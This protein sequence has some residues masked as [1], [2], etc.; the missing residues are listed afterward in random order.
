MDQPKTKTQAGSG[1]GLIRDL[2][3]FDVTMVGVGAMIG[4][5]IFV[6]TGIAAGTAG[7]A[8]ILAFA[9]NGVVTIFTAMVYAELGSA[10]P[11]AGGGYLWVKE[12]L[13]SWNAFLAGWM[14]WFAHAVAG[15][16]YAL[17]FG[18]YF[19]LALRNF[20]VTL[21]G[22]SG[23]PLQKLLA[24]G[25][26]ILFILINFRGV[27]ETGMVGNVVTIGK[28]LILALFIGC[29][30]WTIASHPVYMDKFTPFAP[31]G[32][33]GVLA[34]MGLTFIAFEGYEI[35]VQAGEE[36][37]NPRRN[38][39][40][41][42]FISLAIVIPIYILVAFTALG[43]VNPG[44]SEPTWTW[45]GEHAELGLAEAARQFMPLGTTLLLVG[46][47][48]STMSALNA[49]TFSSTRVSFAMGRD[50]N[51]PDFFSTIHE[52][53]RTPYLALFLSGA[54]IIFIAVAMPIEDVAAATSV[55]FMLLF[56]QVNIAVITIRKKHGDKLDYGYLVP[57]SP[58]LPFINIG[59][60]LILAVFMLNFSVL[61]LFFTLGWIVVGLA[62]YKLYASKREREKELTPIIIQE[63][64]AAPEERFRVLIPIA[65]PKTAEGL[66]RIGSLI[67]RPMK[68]EL[69]LLH[70][71]RVAPQTPLTGAWPQM[72]RIRPLIDS[73]TKIAGEMGV[74]S[75]SMVRLGHQPYKGIIQ[76]VEEREIDMLVIGWRGRRRDRY[77]MLGSNIDEVVKYSP[78]DV[79]VAQHNV[80]VP[81][82]RILIPVANPRKANLLLS[83]GR[84]FISKD[85]EA[86]ITVLH[87]LPRGLSEVEKKGR[88][89]RIK[90]PL[91]EPGFFDAKDAEISIDR[92]PI[93]F[94]FDETGD[95]LS[96]IISRTHES[97]LMIVG[98][99]DESLLKRRI[100]GE[101]PYIIARRSACPV[102]L[103]DQ[104]TNR[105]KFGIQTFFQFFRELEKDQKP[106]KDKKS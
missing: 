80:S 7:P 70:V 83:L 28:I 106:H 87:L 41:A 12:G 25:V 103:V 11:E 43:A 13:P 76:T 88:L 71:A 42:I 10:I 61:A 14:S 46:G 105:V 73:S 51:L 31:E 4:A 33:S 104:E 93:R 66:I 58:I 24:I 34:A 95:I 91:L 97:D 68:G 55:M 26:A 52:R 85:K 30:F 15:S 40:K 23:E 22:L 19:D 17:G 32:V 50:R 2:S 57:F 82:R 8:L 99:S 74:D 60:I 81:A 48:L 37:K 47:L 18:S 65:N 38:I 16:L 79:V 54:F 101:G 29:G 53:T 69:L 102:I 78:C 67:A 44:S 20:H 94:E 21:F 9:L 64:W 90:A 5:G 63:K 62:I 86:R 72:S 92:G 89:D 3:L 56:L 100:F 77:T 1:V 45:L 27:S 6:L 35:I 36:V 75:Q 84:L 98:S 49:T 96:A 59:L 39:P